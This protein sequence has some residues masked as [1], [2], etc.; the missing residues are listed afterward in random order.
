[1]KWMV[2]SHVNVREA[3]VHYAFSRKSSRLM[4]IESNRVALS[5]E[6]FASATKKEA[7]SYDKCEHFHKIN[8]NRIVLHEFHDFRYQFNKDLLVLHQPCLFWNNLVPFRGEIQWISVEN[9]AKRL[10]MRPAGYLPSLNLTL[11]GNWR[12]PSIR[13]CEPGHRNYRRSCQIQ[14]DV[15]WTHTMIATII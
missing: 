9:S 7:S 14:T 8:N 4:T 2:D 10:I 15:Y 11:H 1:M 5:L 3:L 6:W 13:V 12:Q